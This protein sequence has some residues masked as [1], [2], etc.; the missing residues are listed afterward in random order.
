LKVKVKSQGH[1]RYENTWFK[2]KQ[3][4]T[5]LGFVLCVP[6]LMCVLHAA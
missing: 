2:E 6:V 5:E 1:G 4:K 3:K